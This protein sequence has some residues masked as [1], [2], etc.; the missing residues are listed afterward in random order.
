MP[1]VDLRT[2]EGRIRAA[3]LMRS[4]RGL[5]LDFSDRQRFADTGR[6]WE[7]RVSRVPVSSSEL[8][9][10]QGMLIRPDGYICWVGAEPGAHGVPLA[11]ETAQQQL[12]SALQHWFGAPRAA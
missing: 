12:V 11:V 2:P 1:D 7:G 4:G 6:R 3:E 9:G 10:I 5:L 8:A